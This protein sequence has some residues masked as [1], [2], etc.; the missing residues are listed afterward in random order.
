MINVKTMAASVMRRL[1]PRLP[2]ILMGAGT[3]GV[4]GGTVLACCATPK[5]VEIINE[6]KQER[7]R[8]LD[9]LAGEE[10]TKE[11][12]KR[13]RR[14]RVKMVGRVAAVYGPAAAVE[15]LSLTNMWVGYTKMKTAYLGA[16]AACVSLNQTLNAY[17]KA[18]RDEYGED[19]EEKISH[20]YRE[21]EVFRTKEDGT[22]ETVRIRVYPHDVS[23]MPSPYARY[24]CYGEAGAAE[25]SMD[26]N[27][28]FLRLQADAFRRYVE[29][30]R[31]ATLNDLYETLDIRKSAAG[32]HV[33]WI[34]DK[35]HPTGDNYIDLR[36]KIV[37]RDR[38]D[39]NGERNGYEKVILIDPNVDGEIE[40]K[41]VR[42]GLLDP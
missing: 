15:T 14:M 12:K 2:D 1:E 13:L 17:R 20:G 23:E 25:R 9:N 16:S 40:E 39:V 8:I 21:E 27:L 22:T 33:G 19:G 42:M 24:F 38:I 28:T 36:I 18:I 7:Q 37:L 3:A 26:Y 41:A 32:N 29:A 6:Y 34:Y 35:D 30:N 10:P 4:I 11:E 31:I 5:A